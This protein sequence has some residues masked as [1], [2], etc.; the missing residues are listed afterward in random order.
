[1]ICVCVCVWR[2]EESGSPTALSAP[3]VLA[4]ALLPEQDGALGPGLQYE[5]SNWRTGG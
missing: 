5:P 3:V 1:M 4:P 2:E